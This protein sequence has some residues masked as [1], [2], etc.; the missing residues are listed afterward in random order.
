MKGGGETARNEGLEGT[1]GRAGRFGVTLRVLGAGDEEEASRSE[2]GVIK[3]DM[4]AWER[5]V[6]DLGSLKDK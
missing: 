2:A 5:G 4:W 6:W 1:W 3:G